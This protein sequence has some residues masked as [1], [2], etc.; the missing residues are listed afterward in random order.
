MPTII[1]GPPAS[2]KT[3]NAER[4]RAYLECTSIIDNATRDTPIEDPTALVLTNDPEMPYHYNIEAV[5]E[6]LN[7]ID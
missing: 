3:L 6:T 7:E 5:L 1:Y 4:I 2:G